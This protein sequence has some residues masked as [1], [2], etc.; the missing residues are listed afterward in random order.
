MPLFSKINPKVS[1]IV[2]GLLFF[3]T[4]VIVAE[5][6]QPKKT[7]IFKPISILDLP[8]NFS[9]EFVD[10]ATDYGPYWTTPLR[11]QEKEWGIFWT[12][13]GVTG[14]LVLI[15]QP[16]FKS[17]DTK[18]FESINTPLNAFHE[19]GQ[20]QTTA[21]VVGSTYIS[22]YLLEDPKLE[23]AARIATKSLL[24]QSLVN[25]GLK[26]IFYRTKIEEEPYDFRFLPPKWEVPSG[27]AFPSGHASN[28][29]SALSAFALAYKDDPVIPVV[30]YGAATIGSVLLVTKRSHWVSDIV[31]GAALGYYSAEYMTYI[32]DQR[33][34]YTVM[35]IITPN[36]VGLSVDF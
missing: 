7:Y 27:G 34:G 30:C 11:W 2:Q 18:N 15:D 17:I 19:F 26:N 1:L 13:M 3:L 33:T 24:F 36:G 14:A 22:S 23:R 12:V 5:D 10:T 20:W 8:K 31:L 29:W 32:D 6:V 4:T 28:M 35:P 16:L 25:Q 21:L 9:E